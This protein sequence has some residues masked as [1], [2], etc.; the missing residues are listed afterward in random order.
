M[1]LLKE[2]GGKWATSFEH[3]VKGGDK[4]AGNQMSESNTLSYD[5]QC[6]QLLFNLYLMTYYQATNIAEAYQTQQFLQ[7]DKNIQSEATFELFFKD[8]LSFA[9]GKG[10]QVADQNLFR[11]LVRTFYY[12]S[13]NE[14]EKI[15]Q[16]IEMNQHSKISLS[17][18]ALQQFNDLQR[19]QAMKERE[20]KLQK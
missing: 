18:K 13:Q 5:N 17:E 6:Y 15:L 19:D 12:C 20:Q 2:L 4:M 8:A 1:N 7:R 3:A 11:Q 10:F 16:K 14:Y 9:S